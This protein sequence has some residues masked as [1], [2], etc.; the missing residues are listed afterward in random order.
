MIEYT[1]SKAP[2]C[3]AFCYTEKMNTKEHI[4]WVD[5]EFTG[6]DYRTQTIIEIAVIVTDKDLNQI[7]EPIQFIINQPDEVLDNASEW[8]K[9][10]IPQVLEA[11]RK[12][13][14][15]IKQAEE[16]IL[17]YLEK[18]TERG[19][20]PMGGNSIGSDRHMMHY[21]MPELEKWFHYRNVD[22]STFKELVRRWRPELEDMVVKKETHR[23]LDDIIE[24]I[25]EMRIYKQQLFDK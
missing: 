9:E 11:S 15:S 12:S 3:G 2:L 20:S 18:Y 17:E 7:A 25:E 24:S 22:V 21:R 8:V 23:A 1:N 6:I 4:I 16:E 19:V 14:V 13:T 10:H 5:C